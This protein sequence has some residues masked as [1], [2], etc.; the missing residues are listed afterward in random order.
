MALDP[1]TLLV[2]VLMAAATYATR[3]GGLWLADRLSL[4]GRA[5]AWLGYIP[6]AILVSLVA[7]QVLSAGPAGIVA[8]LA[9]LLVARMTGGLIGPMLAGVLVVLTA[10]ALESGLL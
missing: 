9:V 8:A 7:P 5:E 3:A 2:I 10:R 6:G 4:S 1:Q